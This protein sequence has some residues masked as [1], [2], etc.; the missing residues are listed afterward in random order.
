MF[1]KG[2][3]EWY[4]LI[5]NFDQTLEKIEFFIYKRNNNGL[6]ESTDLTLVNNDEMSIDFATNN[7]ELY[8]KILGSCLFQSNIR[9]YDKTIKEEDHNIILNRYIV[10]ETGSILLADNSDKIVY[11]KESKL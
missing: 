4:G 11:T 7:K 10:K 9:I 2:P 8:L 5:V 6:C 3:A 1:Y